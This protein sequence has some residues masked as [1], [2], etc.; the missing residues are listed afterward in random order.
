M[1]GAFLVG[2]FPAGL[3]AAVVVLALG[4]PVAAP[5][6]LYPFAAATLGLMIGA[7]AGSLQSLLV[8]WD[9]TRKN[10][11]ARRSMLGWAAGP[12]LG[13][14]VAV[15][16]WLGADASRDLFG[17]SSWLLEVTTPVAGLI[18]GLALRR[19]PPDP[20]ARS[21]WWT[22]GHVIAVAGGWGLARALGLSGGPNGSFVLPVALASA[23]YGAVSGLVMLR[24][25]RRQSGSDA[26]P[27]P[28]GC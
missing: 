3:V 8:P 11:W 18:L 24:V 15:A 26:P 1:G 23:W 14:I 12:G 9:R 4:G 20:R 2:F 6:L 28:D 22:V 10:A 21:W 17:R 7:I 25:V 5:I 19:I 13:S 16:A 27:E